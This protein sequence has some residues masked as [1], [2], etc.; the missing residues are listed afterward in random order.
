MPSI[1]IAAEQIVCDCWSIGYEHRFGQDRRLQQAF[2]YARLGDNENL[3]AHPLDFNC[4]VD[5]NRGEVLHIDFAPH[6]T[7]PAKPQKL[8]GTGTPHDLQQDSLK[9]SGRDR[10]PPPMD[11]HDYLPALIQAEAERKGKAWSPRNDLKPLHVVQPEGVSF[12]LEGNRLNWQNW[13]MHIGFNYREGIVLNT[14]QY[15]DKDEDRLRPI[16]YRASLAEMVVPYASPEWPHPRK[17][18][19]DVGEYGL[20]MVCLTGQ[21]GSRLRSR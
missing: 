17:F 16:I 12:T 5:S 7:S 4:V 21:V 11:R 8:S 6:R 1:G 3:Y 10:I 18:A 19:F 13:D 14:V 20:G 2:V 9:Q 15:Y